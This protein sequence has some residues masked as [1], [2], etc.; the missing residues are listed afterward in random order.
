MT[1]WEFDV[2]VRVRKTLHFGGPTTETAAR[3]ILAKALCGEMDISLFIKWDANAPHHRF[4]P[5]EA[6]I[7]ND[8]Q[9]VAVR[10]IRISGRNGSIP[11]LSQ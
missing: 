11:D 8:P 10:H 1:L 4:V 6:I 5:I 3:D 7:D 9:I 2:E